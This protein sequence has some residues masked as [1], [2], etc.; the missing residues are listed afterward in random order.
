MKIGAFVIAAGLLLPAAAA[1]AGDA[2]LNG[3]DLRKAISQDR[4]SQH[5]GI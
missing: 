3:D 5:F 1:L 2:T 4:L